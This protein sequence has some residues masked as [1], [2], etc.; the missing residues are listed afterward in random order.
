M[1]SVYTNTIAHTIFRTH[2]PFIRIAVIW[3]GVF[4]IITIIIIIIGC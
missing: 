3:A 1:A 4:F 2:K